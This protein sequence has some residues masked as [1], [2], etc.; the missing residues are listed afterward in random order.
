MKKYLVTGG[1]GFI[2]SALVK[3]LLK[4]GNYVRVFDNNSRGNLRRLDDVID[5]IDFVKGDIRNIS[6]CEKACEGID[7]VCHLAFVN[8]TEYF[9]EKPELV[10]EVG[11]KGMMNIL[12]ASLKKNNT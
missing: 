7:S 1:S 11:V 2:G 9:Y 8:G 6:D 5:N 3:G 4:Q 10:L 12:D